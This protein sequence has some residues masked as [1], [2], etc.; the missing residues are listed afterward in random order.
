MSN[1]YQIWQKI[2][3]RN[4]API[5]V[6][7]STEKVKYPRTRLPPNL[8]PTTCKCVHVV[9]CGH[10]QLCN[11]DD[12]PVALWAGTSL[13]GRWLPTRVRQHSALSAISW[14]SKLRGAMNLQHLQRQNFCSRWISLVEFSA[15]PA[16]QSRHHRRS[17]Q[18]T[19]EG[20][21][22]QRS[23]RRCDFRYVV[24]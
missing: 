9:T 10:F 7:K 20:T 21:P 8:M 5:Q 11:K 1:Q 15:G 12:S 4:Q 24:A 17:A 19:A 18:T 13:P 16:A 23:A 14:H 22:F 3:E 6:S 2:H